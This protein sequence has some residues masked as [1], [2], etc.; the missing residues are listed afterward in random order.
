MTNEEKKALEIIENSPASRKLVD[1]LELI[2]HSQ[3]EQ[4]LKSLLSIPFIKGR[5]GLT[6]DVYARISYIQ[7]HAND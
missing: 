3:D 1:L 5:Q 4:G 2:T 7:R 6:Q